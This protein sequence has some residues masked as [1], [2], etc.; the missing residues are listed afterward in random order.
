MFREFPTGSGIYLPVDVWGNPLEYS[1]TADAMGRRVSATLKSRGPDGQPGTSDDISDS[2]FQINVAEVTPTGLVQG[3]LNFVITNATASPV[4]PAYSALIT[5]S[6]AGGFGTSGCIGLNIGQLNSAE[7][8]PLVQNFSSVFSSKLPI[9]KSVFVP[10]LYPNNTCNGGG[11][12]SANNMTVFISDGLN[13][14]F[15][16]LPTINY[17]VNVP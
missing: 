10:T 6:Y 1:A 17:T 8:K 2:T 11:M 5:A 4:T 13:A 15:V 14:V 3:N 12:S 16:N 7:S 9:G